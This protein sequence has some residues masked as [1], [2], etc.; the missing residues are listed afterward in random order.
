MELE[1]VVDVFVV[2]DG[3]IFGL[4]CGDG[5]LEGGEVGCGV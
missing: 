5:W 4:V 1:I 3:N 2:V